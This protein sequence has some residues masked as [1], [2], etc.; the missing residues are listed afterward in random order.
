MVLAAC[1]HGEAA[2]LG[3]AWLALTVAFVFGFGRLVANQSW[4][5]LIA[6]YNVAQGRTWPFVLAWIAGGSAVVQKVHPGP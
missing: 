6:D 3:T 2:A 4:E 1:Q 5:E